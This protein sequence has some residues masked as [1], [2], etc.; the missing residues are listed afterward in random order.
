[1]QA[2]AEAHETPCS[3]LAMS[4]RGADARWM[5]Q[6][7]PFQRST[8]NGVGNNGELERNLPPTAVQADRETQE[9]PPRVALMVAEGC[10]DQV[11]PF[12]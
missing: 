7:E 5:N 10:A 4:P 3:A 1:M 6:R 11:A 2:L 12:Q 8:S 9:T